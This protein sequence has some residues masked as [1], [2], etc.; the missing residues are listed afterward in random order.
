MYIF[1]NLIVIL[2]KIFNVTIKGMLALPCH[3]NNLIFSF[4]IPFMFSFFIYY[5]VISFVTHL[6]L[7][8]IYIIG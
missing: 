3:I 2:E 1:I 8:K 4:F 5:I 6:I 7:K